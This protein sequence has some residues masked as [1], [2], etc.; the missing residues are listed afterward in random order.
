MEFGRVAPEEI[1]E[2]DFTLPPDGEQT[3]LTLSKG[4]KIAKPLFYVGCAKWGRKE[5]K[6]LIYP[7]KQKRQIF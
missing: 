5:W 3:A 6:D 4:K 2:I 7:K 1:A